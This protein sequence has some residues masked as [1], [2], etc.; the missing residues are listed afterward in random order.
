MKKLFI[1]LTAAVLGI[2]ASARTFAVECGEKLSE[3]AFRHLAGNGLLLTVGPI[4]QASD[5]ASR[6]VTRRNSSEV[7]RQRFYDYQ[8][9]ATAGVAQMSFFSQA[10]GAGVT[11]AAGAVVGSAKSLWDTN[12]EMPNT[13][14][15]GKMFMVESIEVDFQPGLSAA[16]NTYT[17]AALVA[18]AVAAAATVGGSVNDVQTIMNS[19]MLEFN[20]SSKNYLRETP[21]KVFPPKTTI[22]LTAAVASNSATVGE[23]AFAKAQAVGRAYYMEPEITLEPAVNFEVLVRWPAA[24]ATPSGFNGRLGIILDGYWMRASQ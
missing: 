3:V 11:T 19:G 8:L 20:V 24:V 15:S 10:Q 13:L 6:R 9:Y 1:C 2:L 5:F 22:D 23:V 16:A 21:L 17:P 14:P 7:I 4:P 12:L 18:F